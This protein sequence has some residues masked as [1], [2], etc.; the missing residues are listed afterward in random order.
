MQTGEPIRV[1]RQRFDPELALYA[2]G[3]AR[4]ADGDEH[5]KW[6]TSLTAGKPVG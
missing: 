1:V 6:L 5:D 4:F 2:M 3:L